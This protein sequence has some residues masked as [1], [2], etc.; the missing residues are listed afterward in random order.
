[1][2]LERGPLSLVSTTK[3]LLERKSSGSNLETRDYSRRGFAA[4]T[5]RCPLS[6]KVG[7]NFSGKRLSIGRYSSLA[8]SGHRVRLLIKR[9]DDVEAFVKS[10]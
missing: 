2:D 10:E 3:D 8:H 5:T 1:M 4:L 7:T 6:A 9:R